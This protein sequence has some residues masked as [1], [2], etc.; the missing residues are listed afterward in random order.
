MKRSRVGFEVTS[1][2][3]ISMETAIHEA[4]HAAAIYFGNKQRQ[5][6]PV[7][8]QIRIN[9][10][11]V[12]SHWNAEIEGGR[13]IHTLPESV[14]V[15]TAMLDTNQKADYLNAFEADIVNLLIGPLAEANYVA[16]RDDEIINSCLVTLASLPRYGGAA[17]LIV[18]WEYLECW[19]DDP[20]QR[21]SKLSELFLIAFDFI[22]QPTRWRAIIGL[23]NYLLS[24]EQTVIDYEQISRVLDGCAFHRAGLS[25]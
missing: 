15:V 23:A 4:G 22:N 25:G 7:Y 2:R 8:F 10:P 9:Q 13:L 19:F 12:K 6:P 11:D 17:D 18:A 16:Q 3:I 1:N 20:H 5:L 24:C 21:Q 14:A